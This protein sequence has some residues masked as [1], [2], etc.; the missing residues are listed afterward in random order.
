MKKIFLFLIVIIAFSTAC[1]RMSFK[2]NEY[3]YRVTGNSDEFYIT[4]TNPD[5]GSVSFVSDGEWELERE[6]KTNAG[7]DYLTLMARSDCDT[8]D[9]TIEI[10]VNGE[11]IA[12]HKREGFSFAKINVFEDD[13]G[14]YYELTE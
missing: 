3:T 11:S 4:Y 8:C 10:L 7:Y 1:E 9:V 13:E 2:T 12:L 14:N 6:K 5:D